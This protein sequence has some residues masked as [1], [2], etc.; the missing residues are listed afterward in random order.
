MS[1]VFKGETRHWIE[2]A[3][4]AYDGKECK[5]NSYKRTMTMP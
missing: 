5:G 1:M 2:I 3:H 4:D